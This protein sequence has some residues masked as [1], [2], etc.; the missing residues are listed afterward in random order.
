MIPPWYL[1]VTF[2]IPAWY[3][4]VTSMIATCYFHDTSLLLPWYLPVTFMIP[5]CYFHDTCMIPPAVT[6]MIHSWY[7]HVTSIIPS[8]CLPVTSIIPLWYFPVTSM[9]L[10]CK[11]LFPNVIFH[12]LYNNPP[13]YL[14]Q[15]IFIFFTLSV[16]SATV[17]TQ[18]LPPPLQLC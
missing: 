9:I 2:M 14:V 18:H 3:L 10:S 6:S 4:P 16:S 13:V 8:W 11:D 5:P 1:P 7:L 15:Y 12:N 17:I